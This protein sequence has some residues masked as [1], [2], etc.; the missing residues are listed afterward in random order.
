MESLLR[1]HIMT[2]LLNE[3]LLSNKQYGFIS[4]RSTVTQLFNYVDKC[5]E[6]IANGKVVDI[7]YFDFANAFDTVSH[8]R[9]QKK[10]WELRYP[11]TTLEMDNII[12]DRPKATSK[13]QPSTIYDEICY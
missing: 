3:E 10:T 2:H 8:R 11:R 9:L 5:C 6:S 4:K 7:I 1:E 12:L 13:S